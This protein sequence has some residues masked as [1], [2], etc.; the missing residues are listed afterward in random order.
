MQGT[1]SLTTGTQRFYVERSGIISYIR[2][3]I[4]T[5]SSGSPVVVDVLKNGVSVLSTPLSIPAGE[6][7]LKGILA[8]SQL[9]VSAGD[10]FTVNVTGVGSVTTGANLTVTLEVQQ[11][12][13]GSPLEVFSKTFASSSG[14][15]GGF[16]TAIASKAFAASKGSIKIT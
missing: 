5:P 16:R 4:G 9:S 12:R 6:Y 10:Y 13:I 1:L 14:Y 2:A 15:I 7:S 11:V 8:D 3:T